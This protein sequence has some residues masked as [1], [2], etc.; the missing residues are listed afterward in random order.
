MSIEI[1]NIVFGAGSLGATG[2]AVWEV[3][4]TGANANAGNYTLTLDNGGLAAT[5]CCVFVTPRTT[6]AITVAV[7]HTNATSKIVTTTD[8]AKANTNCAFDW[9]IVAAPSI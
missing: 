6:P 7:T 5:E 1:S 2:T 4:A 3:G 9:I 8:N